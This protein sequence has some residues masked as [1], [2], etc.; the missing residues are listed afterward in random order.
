[1]AKKDPLSDTRRESFRA[2]CESMGWR[3]ES[4]RWSTND[5]CSAIG[6]SYQQTSNILNGHGSFGATLAREIETHK[7][8]PAGFFDQDSTEEYLDVPRVN[9]RV[10]AGNGSVAEV[11]DVIGHL[12]FSRSF[13]RACGVTPASAKVVDVVGYS[14][15]PTIKHG[16]VLLLSTANR[17]PA[18]NQIY[19]LADPQDGLIVKRLRRLDSGWVARSDNADFADKPINEGRPM[20]IIGRAIWMGARL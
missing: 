7:G 6:K 18:D 4:G 8:L 14:M 2:W 5:I 9:V 10:S 13:L 20:T 1:M 3:T 16:A 11:E 19:A 15:E 12:K 17:E